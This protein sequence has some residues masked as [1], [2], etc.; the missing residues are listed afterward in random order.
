MQSKLSAIK[1]DHDSYIALH[2]QLHNVLR[3]L[4]ISGRWQ[5]GERIPSEP[6]LAKHLN[7]SRSTVRIAL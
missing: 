5:Q 1:L 2:V 7:I 3:Q 6:R 4:I